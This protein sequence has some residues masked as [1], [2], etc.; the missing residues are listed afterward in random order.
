MSNDK[1]FIYIR[2]AFTYDDTY[3][4]GKTSNIP[5]R[6]DTYKTSELKKGIFILVYEIDIKKLNNY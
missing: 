3:K 6:D 5:E 4:L 2:N 1:G